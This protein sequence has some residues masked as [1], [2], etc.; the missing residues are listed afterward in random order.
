V[1]AETDQHERRENQHQQYQHHKAPVRT[2][3]IEHSSP[4]I[5]LRNLEGSG[6]SCIKPGPAGPE[7]SLC[8]SL[9]PAFPLFTF[10]FPPSGSSGD[11][12]ARIK[13][14]SFR[15]PGGQMRSS[16][17]PQMQNIW[18]YPE[19]VAHRGAGRVAPENTLAA[20]R[21]GASHGFRMMEY[22]VK[23][24]A[25]DV[26]IL[27]HDDTLDRTST[28]SGRAADFRFAEL[29]RHDFGAWHSAEYSGEPIA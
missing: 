7:F 2:Y 1:A 14:L 18:P 16:P 6:K 5:Q 11:C 23:L 28:G 10:S 22:D 20:F 4:G 17:M 3:E 19:W 9:P 12:H 24:T 21:L 25:D 15:Q 8:R 13:C 29:A 26:P 27:L